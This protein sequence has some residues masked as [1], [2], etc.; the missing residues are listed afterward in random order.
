MK[1]PIV[2][3]YDVTTEYPMPRPVTIAHV[4]DLHERHSEDILALVQSVK[5]DLIVVTGDTLERYDNRPQYDFEHKPVKR[6]IINAIHYTNYLLRKFEPKEKKARTANAY[7]FMRGAKEI[8]PV[9]V[10]LG[11]HEQKLSDGDLA[12]YRGQ[13]IT[14]LDNACTKVNIGGFEMTVGGMSSWDFEDF[15]AQFSRLGGYKLLLSHH[16][17]RFEPFI[18]D[19]DVDL[20]LSGHTHGGQI[21]LSSKGMGFFV[22]GQGLFGRYAHGMFFGGRLIVSAGCSNTVA[23]PRIHNPRELAVIT[24]RGKNHGNL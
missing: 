12:F 13:G 2:T 15:L 8:A 9:I 6:L 3:R 18:K 14:L 5:P 4:S 22:P 23:M 1:A 7:A 24:L 11:N 17:E 20:T 19:T 16:P 10:S 21:L